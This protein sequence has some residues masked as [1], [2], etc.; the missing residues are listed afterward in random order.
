VIVGFALSIL[1]KRDPEQIGYKVLKT[2]KLPSQLDEIS[3]ISWMSENEIACVQDENG[4]IFIYDLAKSAVTD[5]IKFAD[6]G[7]YEGIAIKGRDAYVMRSDG[8]LYEV[9]RFRESEITINTYDTGFTYK[10]N[11]ETL[12]YDPV[13]DMLITIP[14]ERDLN[15]EDGKNVYEIQIDSLTPIIKP[16]FEIQMNDPLLKDF[17]KNKLLNTFSPSDIAIDPKTKEYYVLEGKRPKL[18]VLDSDGKI[19]KVYLF[20]WDI[21]PQPE[22]LTIGKDGSL[23]ISTETGGSYA[24]IL[25]IELT[26]Q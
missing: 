10:N 25:Q 5:T 9:L 2:W 3:G 16:R 4:Y 19:K 17:K 18:L 11:M 20:N 12:A 13:K 14:K 24:A 7:D 23:Y 21:V 22:G 26:D 6:A 8:I 1:E 15:D